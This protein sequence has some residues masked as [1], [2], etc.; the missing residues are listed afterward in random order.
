[1]ESI[2]QVFRMN[3]VSKEVRINIIRK[4]GRAINDQYSMNITEELVEELVKSLS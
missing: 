1:M 2:I 3:E 4:L